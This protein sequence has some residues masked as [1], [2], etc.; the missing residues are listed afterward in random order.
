MEEIFDTSPLRPNASTEIPFTFRARIDDIP[1]PMT[2]GPLR[3]QA[4]FRFRVSLLNRPFDESF[5]TANLE[6]RYPIE[7]TM[8]ASENRLSTNDADNAIVVVRNNSSKAYGSHAYPCIGAVH[9]DIVFDGMLAPRC[10][11]HTVLQDGRSVVRHKIDMI[12]SGEEVVLTTPFAV[13]PEAKFYENY[14]WTPI[15]FLREKQIQFGVKEVTVCPA[16]NESTHTMI[17]CW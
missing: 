1:T 5:V 10:P 6:V 13:H 15:L 9:V 17:S 2:P 4:S 3:T 7:I 12:K 8:H 11:I 14:T 16:F